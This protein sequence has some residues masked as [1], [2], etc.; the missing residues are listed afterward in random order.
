MDCDALF[1]DVIWVTAHGSVAM[2]IN[3]HHFA[4]V[5]RQPAL[6]ALLPALTSHPIGSEPFQL[7]G[8]AEFVRVVGHV[9]H[10]EIAHRPDRNGLFAASVDEYRQPAVNAQRNFGVAPAA[11]DWGGPSVGI[12]VQ[13]FL[14]R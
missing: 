1:A 11:K 10:C 5:K 14:G 9:K 2:I 7:L 3:R 4:F 13:T 12:Y 8:R 6:V